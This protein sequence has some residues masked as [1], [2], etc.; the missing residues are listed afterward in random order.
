MHG[1][2]AD[3]AH[4]DHAHDG[5]HIRT[6]SVN[7]AALGMDDFRHLLDVIFKEAQG[8]GVGH[9]DP[10]GVFVH[11]FRDALYRKNT[12]FIDTEG[13]FNEERL[14]QI[15]GAS[16]DEV[17]RRTKLHEITSFEQQDSIINSLEEADFVIV[18]SISSLYRLERDDENV[19]E[20]NRTLGRQMNTLL[21][22]ARTHDVPVLVT[23]Q[24]YSGFDSGKIEPVGGDTVKYDSKIMMELQKNGEAGSRKAILIKHLFKKEGEEA[25]FRIVGSGLVED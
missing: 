1:V 24:V 13:S 4:L 12:V 20:I 2:N 10:D 11:E 18:D 16:Y 8:V 23:N 3:L 21:Q 17:L 5:V 6:V 19:R 15:A 9:H 22:Y 14:K 7:Q 25:N